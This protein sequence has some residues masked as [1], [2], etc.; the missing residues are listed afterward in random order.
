[1]RSWPSCPAP[2]PPTSSES[3]VADLLLLAVDDRRWLIRQLFGHDGPPQAGE[4][5]FVTEAIRLV[6][7]GLVPAAGGRRGTGLVIDHR[8]EPGIGERARAH[9][10]QL[11]LPIALDAAGDD[12]PGPEELPELLRRYRP[13]HVKVLLRHDSGD[14]AAP[15]TMRRRLAET[16]RAAHA[17]DANVLVELRVAGADTDDPE[18]A[19]STAAAMRALG[20]AVEV[21]FWA[22]P[23]QAGAAAYRMLRETADEQGAEC[24]LVTGTG[25]GI[26]VL[27]ERIAQAA[28]EGFSGFAVGQAVWWHALQELHRDATTRS[29]GLAEITE[30]FAACVRSYRS[31]GR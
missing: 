17:A 18:L 26:A 27:E 11:A 10:L 29:T 4:Q 8:L 31:A 7:D 1:M 16:C 3:A 23:P 28:G 14:R 19:E 22:V 15:E 5:P 9:R 25:R 20:G 30:R 13:D 24:L 21:D 12:D 6:L 2:A